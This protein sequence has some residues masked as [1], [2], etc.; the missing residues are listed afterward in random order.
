[1]QNI[2]LQLVVLY[3]VVN[4][5][6][7]DSTSL[8]AAQPVKFLQSI[9]AFGLSQRYADHRLIRVWVFSILYLWFKEQRWHYI[10]FLECMYIYRN[11]I[12]SIFLNNTNLYLMSKFVLKHGTNFYNKML[13]WL[14][15]FAEEFLGIYLHSKVRETRFLPQNWCVCRFD[16]K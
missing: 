13:K 15:G 6:S 7:K 5:A 3:V 16:V 1:M 10:F 11:H 9:G 8:S 12:L 4:V 2:I 14:Q